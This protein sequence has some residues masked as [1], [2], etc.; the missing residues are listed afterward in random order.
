VVSCPGRLICLAMVVER[1]VG[2][3]F[4]LGVFGLEFIP[5]FNYNLNSMVPTKPQL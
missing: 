5:S 2:S 1:G 3:G 4:V